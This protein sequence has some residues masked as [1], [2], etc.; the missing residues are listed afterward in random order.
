MARSEDLIMMSPAELRGMT[1]K[2]LRKVTQQLADA[3]NK[4]IKR[5]LA[6]ETGST[7][8][9]L[10][11]GKGGTIPYYSVAGKNTKEEIMNEYK[12]LRNVL[13]PGAKTSS[14]SAW[15][16]EV[17]KIEQR[18]GRN[19]T[20][21]EWSLYRRIE[22]EYGGQ[23]PGGYD[24][25]DVQRMI[26]SKADQGMSLQEVAESISRELSKAYETEQ[27]Q[28]VEFY[29][30]EEFEPDVYMAPVERDERRNVSSNRSSGRSS[31]RKNTKKK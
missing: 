6:D 1:T 7:S 11:K 8:P 16:K 15:K 22:E 29:D 26:V 20:P 3:A 23:F 14:V 31:G 21:E 5:L 17:K 9:I 12:R 25:N 19:L 24:S 27:L 30:L 28:E 13:R 10:R 18:V 2:E 4:R